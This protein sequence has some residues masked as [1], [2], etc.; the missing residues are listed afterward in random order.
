MSADKFWEGKQKQKIAEPHQDM[1]KSSLS[2]EEK[3]I[4][5]LVI[6]NLEL[7]AR[8]EFTQNAL[9]SEHEKLEAHTKTWSEEKQKLN[10]DLAKS[11]KEIALLKSKLQNSLS[12]EEKQRL[13][14]QVEELK[15][16]K[17][18]AKVNCLHENLAR[19]S[20]FYSICLDCNER[21]FHKVK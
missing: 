16:E 6:E 15:K 12:P 11:F 4:K 3:R 8:L 2:L 14:F 13:T 9:K 19:Q 18:N 10:D 17:E 21:I 20:D 1:K 5:A 7:E